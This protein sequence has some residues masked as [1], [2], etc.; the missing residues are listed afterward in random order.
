MQHSQIY[1]PLHHL[2]SCVDWIGDRRKD[3]SVHYRWIETCIGRWINIDP[4]LFCQ[5]V[6]NGKIFL[7][8]DAVKHT[9]LPFAEFYKHANLC[10][11]SFVYHYTI[12][13]HNVLQSAILQGTHQ[14]VSINKKADRI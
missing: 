3:R 2:R 5:P 10:Q 14:R 6:R 13:I 7:F 1:F 11:Y 4:Q 8:H 12:G 9:A